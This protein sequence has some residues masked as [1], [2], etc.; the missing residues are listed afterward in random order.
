MRRLQS[1]GFTLVELAVATAVAG[2]LILVIMSFTINS[3]AQMSITEARGDL[4]REAQFS[5]D[6][7]TEDA[8][9]SSNSYADTV[10]LDP[11]AP[12]ASQKWQG[13]ASTLI[14]A[15]AAQDANRNILFADPLQY[16][17]HKNNKVYFVKDNTLYR[18]T[19][20]ANVPNNALKTTC[21]RAEISNSCPG[22]SML[23][24]NVS[25]F[26]VKY[27]DSSGEEVPVEQAR[28]I[29]ATLKLS[30]YKYDRDITAE[31]KTR[32]VFRNE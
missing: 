26:S 7:L 9:L 1:A 19:L 25:E 30:I 22:D 15:T 10:I 17:S 8:R 13:D 23:A 32:T 11:N 14:L 16:S 28:S 5:L 20:A 6:T 4:L 31:Y 29:Q 24:H 21:P 12:S 3:F 18:R 27:F 2:I